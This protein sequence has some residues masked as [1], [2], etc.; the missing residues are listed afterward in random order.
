MHPTKYAQGSCILLLV[1]L[2]LVSVFLF[3]GVGMV[4]FAYIQGNLTGTMSIRYPHNIDSAL[5]NR[6]ECSTCNLFLDH[7]TADGTILSIKWETVTQSVISLSDPDDLNLRC[8]YWW[9]LCLQ[10]IRA[11]IDKWN[12]CI[13]RGNN[14]HN[15]CI[16]KLVIG[17]VKH[18]IAT[19]TLK[20]FDL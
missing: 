2:F 17:V 7:K 8:K 15:S 18:I 6:V 3:L 19:L 20:A 12:G 5:T 1:C 11:G 9:A 10:G 13:I 16:Q 4:I 14:V